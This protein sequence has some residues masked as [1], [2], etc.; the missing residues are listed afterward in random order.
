MSGWTELSNALSFGGRTAHTQKRKVVKVSKEES[1][2]MTR[3]MRRRE[4]EE[5]LRYHS[6]E[7]KKR[8]NAIKESLRLGAGLRGHAL[9]QEALIL[10]D[11]ER[12][13]IE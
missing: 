2:S 13:V 12:R 11:D 1:D 4:I 3:Q 10:F 9:F 8:F 6:D 5:L 7:D